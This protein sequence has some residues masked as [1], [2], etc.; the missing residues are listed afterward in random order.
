M[1]S[2]QILLFIAGSLGLCLFTWKYSIKARRPHG[3][4]RFFAFESILL[5]AILNAHAWFERP[6]AWYQIISWVFLIAS[7]VLAVSGFVL[8]YYIG[9]PKGDFENTSKL[10]IIG[11]YKYIR[12]PLYA[13]LIF[14]G[15]GIFFK[16][17]KLSTI[18][19]ALINFI[20]LI[21]TAKREEKEMHIKFGSE[22]ATYMQNTKMFIPLIF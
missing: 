10:V 15:V 2:S 7:L 13:S 4:P 1:I 20:A 16:D 21:A 8:L 12:H 17:I 18:L 5:M 19:L 11:I 22:Y 3:I 9:K 14:L 6:F